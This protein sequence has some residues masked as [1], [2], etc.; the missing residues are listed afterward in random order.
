MKHG[1]INHAGTSLHYIDFGG[2]GPT[3]LLLHGLMGRATTWTDTVRWLTPSYRVIAMD[4]RGH[5][6][7]EKVDSYSR[8]DYVGD[9]ISLIEQLHLKPV[10]LIGHSMGALN[11]WVLAARRPDLVSAVVLEDMGADTTSRSGRSTWQAWFDRWPVPFASLQEVR[12]FF[13]KQ[14]PSYAEYFME[15]MVE[16]EDGYYPMF[17]FDHMLQSIDDWEA[18]S[19]WPELENVQSPAL[20]VRGGDGD[21]PREELEEMARRMPRGTFVE[22]Q[23]AG[24]VVHYDQPAA[25]R[26]AVESFLRELT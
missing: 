14:K 1:Y 24:H 12:E 23:Q 21:L 3:V 19:Y 22:I 17:Q 13:G 16:R 11:A 2:N 7:S 26:V 4:Q 8:D 5:G 6:Q 20:V 18:H 25:W 10:I 15:F 9:I